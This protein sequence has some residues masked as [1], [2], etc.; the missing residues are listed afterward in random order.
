[1][2]TLSPL[3]RPEHLLVEQ[4]D[5]WQ[6][7]Q[8]GIDALSFSS[9]MT[10]LASAANYDDVRLWSIP[11]RENVRILMRYGWPAGVATQGHDIMGLAFS[12][13]DRLLAAAFE[14]GLVRLWD[15]V[16]ER[17]IDLPPHAGE[18]TGLAFSPDG[19]FLCTSAR[20]GIVA[21][22]DTQSYALV[23]TF[24]PAPHSMIPEVLSISPDSTQQAVLCAS[25]PG[26]AE[27]VPLPDFKP[28]VVQIWELHPPTFVAAYVQTFQAAEGNLYDFHFQR[29]GKHIALVENIYENETNLLYLYAADTWTL[30]GRVGALGDW[31]RRIAYSPDGRFLAAGGA[32]GAVWLWDIATCSLITHFDA[33]TDGWDWRQGAVDWALGAVAW[34][35]S[36]DLIATG[37]KSPSTLYDPSLQRY[38]GPA[39]YT[40]KLWRL[41][42][43]KTP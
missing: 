41:K 28:A 32:A 26:W 30:R 14:D 4:E 34:A 29:D 17:E 37:G 27:H 42:Q 20:D 16:G 12:P 19:R 22:W 24:N 6:G 43:N 13:N 23:S 40:I 35:P 11:R 21:I 38:T 39:D 10:L 2:S 7:H 36:G 3:E 1:M 25:D 9:D 18:A 8:S 5:V 31:T 15:V 33:H